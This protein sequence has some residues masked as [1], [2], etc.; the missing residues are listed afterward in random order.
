MSKSVPTGGTITTDWAPR[1]RWNL[2]GTAFVVNAFDAIDFMLLALALPPIIAEFQLSFAE[3]GLLGTAT[4][5]GVGISGVVVGR[6]ADLYGRKKALIGCILVFATMTAIA[7]WSAT[8]SQLLVLRFVAGFG[9]GGVWS[10]LTT[11]IAETWPEHRR[12]QAA[13]FVMS[14]WP[15]GIIIAALLVGALLPIY[16]WRAVFLAGG[17]GLLLIPYIILTIPESPGW[18]AIA[19]HAEPYAAK[20]PLSEIFSPALRRWTILGTL[21]S[22]LALIAYWGVNTWLPTYLVKERGLS[23]ESMA[24]FII[25]LNIGTILGYQAFG[26]FADRAGI[27]T[28]LIV[29]LLGG[30]I[31]LP[32][33]AALRDAT[34]LFWLGP[35]MAFFFAFPG[36]MGAYFPRLYPARVRS[37]GA[38]FCFNIGRGM[39]AFAPFALGGLASIWGLSTMIAVCGTGFLCAAG[40]MALL[41]SLEGR[42]AA[43]T[44][45]TAA[46]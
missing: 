35:I 45:A 9:L 27:R 13:T 24:Q 3:A 32:I 33:Y 18:T 29:S 5:V 4:L 2:L 12:G 17:A 22:T 34:L 28:A 31:M 30:A 44:L 37:L 8:W 42:R 23:G 20:A 14:A 39:S 1:A 26:W 11:Y 10:V 21:S 46:E 25:F 40:A 19:H 7:A 16:G 38:G 36:L 43:P 6:M 15:T 41:P